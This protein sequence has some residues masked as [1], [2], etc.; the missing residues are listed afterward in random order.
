MT[1]CFQ[2]SKM[3]PLRN[4]GD[5]LDRGL[6]A[7]SALSRPQPNRQFAE[8]GRTTHPLN[9]YLPCMLRPTKTDER[10]KSL[11]YQLDN[12]LVRRVSWYLGIPV[13]VNGDSSG[14]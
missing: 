11:S 13:K 9:L 2:M 4:V 6:K 8:E 5:A 7:R 3:I 14:V 10:M 12:M 1:V